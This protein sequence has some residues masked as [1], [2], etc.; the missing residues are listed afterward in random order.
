MVHLADFAREPAKN[1]LRRAVSLKAVS[2]FPLAMKAVPDSFVVTQS[3][4]DRLSRALPTSF[5]NLS[6]ASS[7]ASGFQGSRRQ[8]CLAIDL[9]LARPRFCRGA[10]LFR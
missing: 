9:F 6:A 8:P 1:W 2:R 4:F 7:F 5:P 3:K 10:V